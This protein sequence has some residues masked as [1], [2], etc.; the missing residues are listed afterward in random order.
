MN[1]LKAYIARCEPSTASNDPFAA[2][3]TVGEKRSDLVVQ[4]GSSEM[5]LQATKTGCMWLG[6]ASRADIKPSLIIEDNYQQNLS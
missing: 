3:N 6:N 1:K 5:K 2:F 4:V